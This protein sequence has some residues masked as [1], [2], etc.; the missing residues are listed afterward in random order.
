M[1]LQVVHALPASRGSDDGSDDEGD[2]VLAMLNRLSLGGARYFRFGHKD[3]TR[4]VLMQVRS[5][6]VY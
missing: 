4:D 6:S 3:N 5:V 2:S 1:V